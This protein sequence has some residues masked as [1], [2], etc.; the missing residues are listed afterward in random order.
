MSASFRTVLAA[1]AC[2][3][4]LATTSAC[5]DEPEAK[6]AAPSPSPSPSATTAAPEPVGPPLKVVVTRVSGKLPK[7]ARPALEANVGR[8]ISGYV[9]NAF[10]LGEYPRSSFGRAF[11]TFSTGAAREA[12]RRDEGLLTNRWLGPTT[13]SVR[14]RRQTAYLSVLAPHK[15]AAG[16]TARVEFVF[17]VDRGERPTQRVRLAGRLMLTRKNSGGWQIFG[18]DLARS[19]TPVGSGS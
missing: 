8:A 7:K 5:T 12:R 6:K 15:V 10:L 16:V 18:Y 13:E 11:S 17:A 9:R 1:T 2:A 3:A 4:L 14:V 19:N